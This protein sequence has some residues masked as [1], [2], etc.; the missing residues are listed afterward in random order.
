MGSVSDLTPREIDVLS[1]MATGLSNEGIAAHLHLSAKTIEGV[2]R[3]IFMKLDLPDGPHENRRVLA[4]RAFLASGAASASI[5]D[6]L[7]RP[8]SDFIG[9]PDAIASVAD[10][11][12]A[13]RLLTL[14]GP[15]GVGKTRLAAEAARLLAGTHPDGSWMVDLVACTDLDSVLAEVV[16]TVGAVTAPGRSTVTTTTAWFVG[17]RSL[18]LLDNAEHVIGPIAELVA[19]L[20]ARCPTVAVVVT[21]RR[22]LGLPGEQIRLVEPLDPLTD[23]IRLVRNRLAIAGIDAGTDD[24]GADGPIGSLCDAVDGLPLALE[25]IAARLRTTPASHLL[26]VESLLRLRGRDA[27]SSRHS[28]LESTIDWSYR[29]LDDEHARCFEQLSVFPGTFDLEAAAAV[30]SGEGVA[31][32]GGS[33]DESVTDLVDASLVAVSRTGLD[34]RYRLLDTVRHFA[35][36]RLGARTASARDSHL[37]YYVSLGRRLRWQWASPDQLVADLR[38]DREWDDFRAALRWA[39]ERGDERSCEA[40]IAATSEHAH[41]RV[42]GEHAEW[43]DLVLAD[44]RITPTCALLTAAASWKLVGGEV[45]E[46][47]ALARRAIELAPSPSHPSAAEATV[48]LAFAETA[49]GNR[50]SAL[51]LVP[52]L[53]GFAAE[54]PDPLERWAAMFLLT[55]GR[56]GLDLSQLTSDLDELDRLSHRIGAPVLVAKSAMFQ[57]QRLVFSDGLES[58]AQQAEQVVLP[59]ARAAHSPEIEAWIWNLVATVRGPVA[60]HRHVRDAIDRLYALR[61]WA[62]LWMTVETAAAHL[63]A[64]GDLHGAAVVLGHLEA[65]HPANPETRAVRDMSLAPVRADPRSV[66]SMRRGALLDG[67][68]LV[69]H[70]RERF[71]LAAVQPPPTT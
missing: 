20:L 4:V 25:L 42:R 31:L 66:E 36:E 26:G 35:A 9:R 24:G 70:L 62:M 16:G 11:V 63:V 48:R 18:L 29:L 40:I 39:V 10:A 61:Y 57:L 12:S 43:A 2:I 38:F 54:H 65:H 46:A 41:H 27:V 34:V 47:A 59:M 8:T 64:T 17:R 15:G 6:H 37:L 22:P 28:S 68:G 33:T 67:D 58:L 53:R 7:P 50:D 23:G 19:H 60:D 49:L 13:G 52:R 55:N 51:E 30:A 44:E 45:V 14:V 71:D 32:D 69:A 21:S 56:L 1:S 5:D 3:S